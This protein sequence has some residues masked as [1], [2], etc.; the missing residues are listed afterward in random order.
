MSYTKNYDPW[1]SSS[2]ITPTVMNNFENIYT[3][4][5][6]YLSSH[7]H[8]DIYYTKTEM[9]NTFWYA[10]NDGDGSGSDADLIYYESGNLHASE[11]IGMGVSPG[12][13]VMWS[14]SIEDVPSD[15]ALCDGNSGTP[16]F[17]NIFI[18]GAGDSFSV[19][20]TGGSTTFSASGTPFVNGHELSIAEIPSH[21][22][23]FTDLYCGSY[24]WGDP[25]SSICSAAVASYGF[26]PEAGTGAAH[27]HF[28]E[29]G[30]AFSANSLSCMPYF[31]ALAFIQKL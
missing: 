2:P 12:L 18:V 28:A 7:N 20:D 21:R 4:S 16:D 1:T 19:G 31:Y 29:E 6:S 23:P 27:G 14:G 3:E 26:T 9:Q 24:S 5:S 8:D 10:G 22:H 17:R 25:G 11:F 13:V 30:T 15:W